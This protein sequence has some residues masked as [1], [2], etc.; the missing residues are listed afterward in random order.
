M[1]TKSQQLLYALIKENKG[2]ESKTKLAKLQYFADFI[3]FAFYGNPIS[4]ANTVY[5]RQRQGPLANT[6]SDDLDVLTKEK[7][8][9]ENF[10]YNYKDAEKSKLVSNLS[11][12]ELKTVRYVVSLYGK[13]PFNQLVD[14][15]HKQVPYLSSDE[16]GIVEFFTAYNL[17]EDYKDYEQ[18]S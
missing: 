3:H 12:Q 4:E 18:F 17:I 11:V 2:V 6:L 5:T 9:S 16:N 15:S 10:P 13:L 14:I 7:L 1:L 8:I